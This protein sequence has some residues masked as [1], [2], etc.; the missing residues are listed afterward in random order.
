MRSTRR[1]LPVL[2]AMLA[3][4][5]GVATHADIPASPDAITFPPLEF[6]PPEA[7]SF[8]H[9]LAGGVP[10][11]L[12][13]S[14]EFPLI[15]V[16]FT[17]RGGA[18]LEESNAAGLATALGSLMRRGGT[19]SV[20]ARELDERFDFLAA[21][22]STSVGQE[23]ATA[24]LDCLKSNFPEAFGLF[25]DVLRQ[26]GFDAER[27]RLHQDEVLEELKQRNDRPMSVAQLHMGELLYGA[28]HF[29]GRRPTAASIEAITPDALRRLHSRIF[30]PG[31]LAVAVTG[32]F[33][34]AVM[35][36]TLDRALADWPAGVPAGP[37]PAPAKTVEPG[38]YHASVAQEELP[39]GTAIIVKRAVER[40]HP[41][42]LTLNVMN[43]ILGGGGFT[44]RIM[45]RVRSDEGLAYGASSF[46]APQVHF[47]GIF[48]AFFQSK[49]RTVA[50]ATKIIFEEF[51]RI[52]SE[53]VSDEEL[54]LAKNSFI[55][56][57][58][59]RFSSKEAVL[60]TFVNDELTDR[61]PEY[62]HTFRDRIRRV[63]KR[64]VQRVARTHLDP[65]AMMILVVGDW[66][67]IYGGDLDGRASMNDFF[68][69]NV[70]HLPMRDPLTL[71]PMN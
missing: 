48:G 2:A 57:F 41:D 16:T 52:R 60:G 4:A 50:L 43:H 30:H 8:R 38:L 13:T 71:E 62:W 9:E 56:G 65:A 66:G 5:F 21:N 26:P 46:I 42:M 33:D 39:Q 7:T 22:V 36:E 12:A 40:D 44:S 59:Q 23:Y 63:T 54:A 31:N 27:L 69:G 14:R 67:E 3:A 28:D 29:L 19:V 47:P 20:D 10:V 55:E 6:T 18:Y 24:S 64:D 34:R 11:Y 17:F 45:S 35:L 61:D 70:R 49:N 53:P 37:P 1:T 32:D 25:M 68:G 58:P 15:N 51:D